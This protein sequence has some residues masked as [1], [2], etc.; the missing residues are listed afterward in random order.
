MPAEQNLTL[1]KN[2]RLN[3]ETTQMEVLPINR[4]KPFLKMKLGY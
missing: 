2:C 3:T 4:F 1:L